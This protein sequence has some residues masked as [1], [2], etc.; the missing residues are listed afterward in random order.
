MPSRTRKSAGS[1]VLI[2]VILFFTGLISVFLFLDGKLVV[3][4]GKLVS[5]HSG[6]V[7]F[8]SPGADLFVDGRFLLSDHG[9]AM[10]PLGE[11]DF[12]V[13]RILYSSRCFPFLSVNDN[14]FAR[15]DLQE[16]FLQKS[17]EVPQEITRNELFWDSEGKG[18]F[19]YDKTRKMIFFADNNSEEIEGV[20]S[21][22]DI[23]SV[24][25]EKGK[26]FLL[27]PEGEKQFFSP[28]SSNF[29]SLDFSSQE[30]IFE[31]G[32]QNIFSIEE[33]SD[34]RRVEVSFSEPF[35]K[36]IPIENSDA[37]L[38]VFPSSVYL[39]YEKSSFLQKIT[40]KDEGSE[41]LFFKE[42]HS[43]FWTNGGILF[44]QWL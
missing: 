23:S 35:D 39:F 2:W 41:I 44:R 36:V 31:Y 29:F 18:F 24:V 9:S 8:S 10:L 17:M 40:K 12:C 26:Y 16:V 43:L 19:W 13:S 7:D 37:V 27:S 25:F 33:D 1:L 5:G 14:S 11:Y 20:P 22:F 4:D 15:T 32:K 38:L 6:Y 21:L 34:E 42:K 30:N 28:F 3:R